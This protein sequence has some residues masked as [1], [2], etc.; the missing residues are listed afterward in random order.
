MLMPIVKLL[1]VQHKRNFKMASMSFEKLDGPSVLATM[2]LSIFRLFV[3]VA[4]V[5][6]F[7]CLFVRYIYIVHIVAAAAAIV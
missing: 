2:V 5:V 4:V 6:L 3:A 7:V 1:F